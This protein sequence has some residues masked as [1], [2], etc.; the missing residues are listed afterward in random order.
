MA[1]ITGDKVKTGKLSKSKLRALDFM[2]QRFPKDEVSDGLKTLKTLSSGP[3]GDIEDTRTAAEYLLEQWNLFRE[4]QLALQSEE[5]LPADDNSR[6]LRDA[7][8][9][10]RRNWIPIGPAG[11]EQ[12]QAAGKPVVSGRVKGIAVAP[13]GKRVYIAAANGGVWYSGDEGNSWTP[14]MNGINYFPTALSVGVG[15]GIGSLSCGA[16]ALVPGNS[17]A[18]DRLYVGTGDGYSTTDGYYGIGVLVSYNGGLTWN[19]ESADPAVP[20]DSLFGKGF[21]GL[22]VHPNN[23]DIVFGA[24]NKGIYERVGNGAGGFHWVKRQPSIK[25]FTGICVSGTA[26]NIRFCAAEESGVVYESN[27]G[28]W[29]ALGTDFPTVAER[30]GRISIAMNA[31]NINVVYAIIALKG[32]V[33]PASDSNPQDGHLLGI[34]RFDASIDTKWRKIM[35][36]PRHIFGSNLAESGQGDYDIVIAV[37][38]DNANRIYV[39]GSTVS[40]ESDWVGALYRLDLNVSPTGQT[41][42]MNPMETIG[43]DVHA[44]LHALTFAPNEPEKLWVGCDGGVFYT[45]KAISG[46]GRIFKSCNKGLQ[47][48]TLNYLGTHPTEEEVLFCGAQDNGGIRYTGEDIWLHSTG[49]DGGYYLANWHSPKNVIDTYNKNNGRKRSNGGNRSG[50]YDLGFGTW[51]IELSQTPEPANEAED[52]L[53]YAPLVQLPQEFGDGK[54]DAEREKLSGFLAFGT[55]R[56]WISTDFGDNWKPLRSRNPG[57][58]QNFLS[59]RTILNPDKNF[60]I[61]ALAF[62][63]SK[64]LLVG[65]SN[66]KVFR[67]ADISTDNAWNVIGPV[68]TLANQPAGPLPATTITDFEI[69]PGH[70]D[71]FFVTIGGVVGGT[72][73]VWF[74]DGATWTA[75]SGTGANVLLNVHFNA[76]VA[77]DENHLF[78]GSDVGVWESPDAGNN[79]MPFSFGLPETAVIDLQISKR[80]LPSGQQLILL[81]ASTYG[82]GVFEYQLSPPPAPAAPGTSIDIQLYLRDHYLDKGRYATRLNMPDPRDYGNNIESTDSPDIKLSRPDEHGFYQYRS[83]YAITPG[84]FHLDLRDD[85]N[86]VPVPASGRAITKVY[87]QVNNRS[88]FPAERVWVM[89]LIHALPDDDLPILPDGYGD[90]LRAGRTI[91]AD[92]W[93]TVGLKMTNG[94]VASK[95]AIVEFDLSSEILPPNADIAFFGTKFLLVALLHHNDDAFS[96]NIRTLNPGTDGNLLL[97][98]EKKIAVKRIKLKTSGVIPERVPTY[99]PLTGFSPIPASATE[100]GSPIDSMLAD[101]FRQN[102]HL[103][104]NVFASGFSAPFASRNSEANPPALNAGTLHFADEIN[105]N[106]EVLLKP[107]TP[108]IWRARN[109]IKI[110]AK[111]N[112]KGMGAP[113]NTDGDFGGSG[114]GS[115]TTAG[116]RCVLPLTNP[117]IVMAAGAVNTAG[118]ALDASWASRCSLLLQACKGAGAGS[119]EGADAGG[120]GG[121][122]VVLCAPVI[123]FDAANGSIDV[124]GMPGAGNGGCGGGGLV[125]LYAGEI[126]GLRA[127]GAN[128]NVLVLGGQPTAPGTGKAGGNGLLIQKIIS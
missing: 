45:T 92:G 48:L 123:E 62:Q 51:S 50:W 120:L 30:V 90:A 115:A 101:S 73:H 29:T 32:W 97:S 72:N 18:D 8:I 95:P 23:P 70:P 110:A 5:A 100:A 79:W 71:Q 53:F 47:T 46:T 11:V 21:Y 106:S 118:V 117:A 14:M 26:P 33:N 84:E 34:Y 122:I 28:A 39:G 2:E 125:L 16:L 55:Q 24:T 91:E 67:Y 52:L 57:N 69:R 86:D 104:H 54:T 10:G 128:P 40:F 6:S 41:R 107:G 113:A 119:T 65:L 56:P 13:G 81:R 126:I 74:Y 99:L 89:L 63:D 15:D 114:G 109:K 127:D 61:T 12:G 38:P 93:K 27:G 3:D 64:R 60:Q 49:G 35:D 77:V 22:A 7:P 96:S 105:I 83:G 82:R 44:D 20:A 1:Q 75:K 108:L 94:T 111:I 112:G 58:K 80:D 103:L 19:R 87:V 124:S 121:G 4:K 31:T 85:A 68:E 98:E 59:D 116:K 17:Q 78:A 9:A 37:A 102:D 66:G 76:I 25:G 36:A 43:P 88:A 42:V